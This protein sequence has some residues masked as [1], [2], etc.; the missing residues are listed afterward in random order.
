[1]QPIAVIEAMKMEHSVVAECNGRVVEVRA[2]SGSQTTEGDILVVLEQTPDGTDTAVAAETV[3]L[4]AIRPDL[5]AVLDRHAILYDDARPQAVARRRASGQRSGTKNLAD[6]CDEGYF[7]EYGALVVAAQASR[8]TKEDLIA[9]TP[10][11]GIVTGIG[12]IN[13]AQFGFDQSL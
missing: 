6:L 7:V 1:G 2:D 3:D 9:N 5:Q 4:T 8:R 13:G 12:N 11:D 10:A